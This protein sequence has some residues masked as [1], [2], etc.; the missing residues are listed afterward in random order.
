MATNKKG[1][2]LYCDL[3]HTV[4]HLTDEQAG[5]LFKHV[6]KYVNDDNPE[7]NNPIVNIAFE[8]IKQQLK[9]DLRKFEEVKVKRS[10]AGKA[11]AE[12]RK[13]QKQQ[14]STSV[15][16]VQQTST[17]PTVIDTVNV[18]VTDKD[19][20]KEI[21]SFPEFLKYSV[22]KKPKVNPDDLELKYNSWVENDWKDG[23]DKPINNW[24]TKILNTLPYISENT[25]RTNPNPTVNREDFFT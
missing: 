1:F 17:N 4:Q 20:N 13:Q 9:R 7:S 15:E 5:E 8:P 14:V 3:I 23:N 12:K 22:S 2:I 18:T 16:S 19:I 21:P 10:E 25:A 11:S 24:K 6:L